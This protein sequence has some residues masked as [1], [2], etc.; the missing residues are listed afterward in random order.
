MQRAAMALEGSKIPGQRYQV[1]LFTGASV[2]ADINT[3]LT[4]NPGPLASFYQAHDGTN[5]VTLVL[6]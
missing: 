3:L 2:E 6:F 5:P 4:T 1:K